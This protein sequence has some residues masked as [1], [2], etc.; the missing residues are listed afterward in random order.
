MKLAVATRDVDLFR[1]VR[2]SFPADCR[3]SRLDQPAAMMP[4][5]ANSEFSGLLVDASL[6]RGASH[7]EAWFN[8]RQVPLIVFKDEGVSGATSCALEA[9]ADEIV[10]LPLNSSE[11]YLRTLH[12]LKRFTGSSLDE[13]HHEVRFSNCRLNRRTGNVIVRGEGGDSTVRLTSREFAILWT[14]CLA[15]DRYLSRQEMA[16]SVW[17]S[18]EEIVGRTLEQHI[19]SLRKKLATA[20][21]SEMRIRTI[22]GRG[23]QLES[24]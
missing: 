15:P 4:V 19:Y 11:V 9:N 5:L 7:G 22:Y 6:T 16:A 18:N 2:D 21:H 10:L 24:C 17:A 23:Y 14:L 8:A 3:F 13:G 12:A 20:E 1:F